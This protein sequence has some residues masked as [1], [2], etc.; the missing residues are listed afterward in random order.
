ML[1]AKG[2]GGGDGGGSGAV[3]HACV[4]MPLAFKDAPGALL[5]T[6]A[7]D[8]ALWMQHI[9]ETSHLQTPVH[10]IL[11]WSPL[12]AGYPGPWSFWLQRPGRRQTLPLRR[13]FRRPAALVTYRCSAV[14]RG[15]AEI[16]EAATEGPDD[17]L[18]RY[19]SCIHLITLVTH[20]RGSVGQLCPVGVTAKR[21]F[22]EKSKKTP[23]KPIES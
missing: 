1:D 20:P 21:I 13:I 7:L 23:K 9:P 18:A 22:S 17:Y 10:S 12:D 3:A 15:C 11:C 2:D 16:V 5:A 8:L 6:H 19:Q 4:R 14:P